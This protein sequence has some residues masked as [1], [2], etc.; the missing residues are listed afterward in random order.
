MKRMLP[1]YGAAAAVLLLA[2]GS[3]GQN[4]TGGA[5]TGGQPTTTNSGGAAG[6]TP[7]TSSSGTGGGQSGAGHYVTFKNACQQTIWAAALNA[8]EYDLPEK[9]G[10]KLDP[11]QSY[12]ITL[13][14]AWGGRFWGRTGCTF[15]QNGNG[16]CDTADCG[17]KLEC[18]GNGGKPPATLVEITFGG[19][20]GKDFYDVTL[21]DGYNL[22]MGVTPVPGTFTKSDP[23][24]TYDC[25]A[26]ACTSDVN[27]TC[28]PELQ[29]K[30][31]A[32]QV[33][34]CRSAHE[35]CKENPQESRA[36]LRRARQS[37]QVHARRPQRRS[38]LL[39]LARRRPQLLRLPELVPARR[40]QEHQPQ[41]G[42]ARQAREVRQDLQGRLPHGLQLSLRQSDQHLHVQGR[43]LRD[44]LLPVTRPGPPPAPTARSFQT[45][46]APPRPLRIAAT[47]PA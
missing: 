39:L 44:H 20:G 8:P 21:V 15:D 19:F 41:V 47:D 36:R 12:T 37:L 16:K 13:P 27:P 29:V 45:P 5:A 26:P 24:D 2:C 40:L 17:G 3:N 31:A 11:G 42:A 34:A 4:G 1:W 23:N 14:D 28:P 30:N 32:N 35:A 9:G 38:R 7:S 33:V 10:W 18:N 46:P 43:R 6:S 22:P 25:G